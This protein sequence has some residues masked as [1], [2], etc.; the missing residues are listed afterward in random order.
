[1]LV[2]VPFGGMMIA[3]AGVT[4]QHENEANLIWRSLI[5]LQSFAPFHAFWSSNSGVPSLPIKHVKLFDPVWTVLEDPSGCGTVIVALFTT[6]AGAAVFTLA[7]Y[8]GSVFGISSLGRA[9]ADVM[10]A[11]EATQNP[12]DARA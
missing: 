7:M 2:R 11:A 10:S 1:M 5:G 9:D 3:R 6:A 12:T 8:A 4:G